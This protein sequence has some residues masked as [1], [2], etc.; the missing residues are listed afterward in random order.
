MNR[1]RPTAITV[2]TNWIQIAHVETPGQNR[3]PKYRGRRGDVWNPAVKL[4]T[5][6]DMRDRIVGALDTGRRRGEMLKIQ[7][8]HVDSPRRSDSNPEG[9]FET[10]APSRPHRNGAPGRN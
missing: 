10:A 3:T 2:P 4:T 8:A 1:P 6:D 7:N 9:E 5:G